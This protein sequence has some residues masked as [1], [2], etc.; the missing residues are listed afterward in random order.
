M[1][2]QVP[3]GIIR[4]NENIVDDMCTIMDQIQTYA[5]SIS[6]TKQAFSKDGDVV[7]E[8]EDTNFHKILIGGDQLTVTRCRGA[9]AA[10]SDHRT[11]LEC[12]RGLVPVSED[13][14]AKRIFLMV[15]IE[16]FVYFV[17]IYSPEHLQD[18]L[19][20][21]FPSGEGNLVTAKGLDKLLS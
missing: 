2:S 4:K 8:I 15:N 9:A 12:L 3:L 14:H 19:Q 11:S 10:R 13:W 16:L 18:T 1:L 20:R 5:P 21:Q 7:A 6:K 17:C